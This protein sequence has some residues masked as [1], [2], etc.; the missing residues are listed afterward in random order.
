MTSTSVR[1]DAYLS[2]FRTFVS[3]NEHGRV[4]QKHVTADGLRLG[5]W[6]ARQRDLQRG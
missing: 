5:K 6:V 3:E 4:P 1:A 2:A